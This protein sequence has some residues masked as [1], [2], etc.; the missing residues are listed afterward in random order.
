MVFIV[1]ENMA[2]D[3][4]VSGAME[5]MYSSLRNERIL[6]LQRAESN[7]EVFDS[8]HSTTTPG[9][10]SPYHTSVLNHSSKSGFQNIEDVEERALSSESMGSS[11]DEERI[12]PLQLREI[13]SMSKPS[14]D[15]PSSPKCS[16]T[17]C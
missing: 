1:H 5:P 15:E 7:L 17:L 9:L 8:L 4:D 16:S 2:S 13:P 11:G 6:A 3:A 14:S 10:H 12:S